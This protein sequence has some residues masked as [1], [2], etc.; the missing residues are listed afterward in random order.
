MLIDGLIVTYE[1]LATLGLTILVVLLTLWLF[2]RPA[3]GHKK[4]W[5]PYLSRGIMAVAVAASLTRQLIATPEK[6]STFPMYLGYYFLLNGVI[7]LQVARSAPENT[8]ETLAAIASG[9]GG[10][11]LIIA[12]PLNIYHVTGVATNLGR[13]IFSTIVIVIG[14]LQVQGAV[15]TTPQ[16]IVKHA[17]AAFGFLEVILGLVVIATPIDW[18]ANAVAFVWA[19]LISIYMLCVAHRLRKM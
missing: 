3:K 16:P 10:L 2:T 7:S 17:D 11:W 6:G 12:Y 1:E 8:K 13:F 5:L 18:E 14:L 4:K 15:R 9:V 19:V